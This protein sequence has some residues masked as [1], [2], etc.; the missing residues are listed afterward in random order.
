M[1]SNLLWPSLD[2]NSVCFYLNLCFFCFLAICYL[3]MC[4]QK[5]FFM[6]EVENFVK[7]WKTY[8]FNALS[9]AEITWNLRNK[10]SYISH[11]SV[12]R[13]VYETTN[14]SLG[15]E[16]FWTNPKALHTAYSREAWNVKVLCHLYCHIPSCCKPHNLWGSLPWK[17]I[18]APLH[19]QHL[20]SSSPLYQ[21]WTFSDGN[22]YSF[23]C[24]QCIET[25]LNE[26]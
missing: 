15:F 26:N 13:D 23:T 2:C 19:E 4:L 20:P 17:L 5:G 12:Y 8:E 9:S 22:I 21:V 25:S 14:S 6:L 24:S 16:Q 7:D 18:N 1:C 10:K 11:T 3:N